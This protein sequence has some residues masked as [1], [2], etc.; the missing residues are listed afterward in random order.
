MEDF[1]H[2]LGNDLFGRIRGQDPVSSHPHDFQNRTPCHRFWGSGAFSLVTL[3]GAVM[4]QGLVSMV[5]Q[6]IFGKEAALAFILI[7]LVM[8]FG[9]W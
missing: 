5:P 4:R 2:Y 3:I 9:K 1:S 7:G 6:R 8:F